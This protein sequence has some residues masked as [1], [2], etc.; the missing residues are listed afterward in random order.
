MD[1]RGFL[2]EVDEQG[3]VLLPSESQFSKG[4]DLVYR[5]WHTHAVTATV[6]G[7]V[8]CIIL[9]SSLMQGVKVLSPD[10]PNE[11][12]VL[13]SL[14]WVLGIG[15]GA[16]LAAL[17]SRTSPTAVG[18]ISAIPASLVWVAVIMQSDL[19]LPA[20]AFGW[21]PPAFVY[22]TAFLVLS[23]VAGIAGGASGDSMSFE[24][25]AEDTLT[26]V[27]GHIRPR[28]WWW[29][30]I[31]LSSWAYV[32]PTVAYLFWLALATGWHWAVHPSLWFNWRWFLFLSFGVVLTYLPYAVFVTGITGACAILA[33]GKNRRLRGFQVALRFIGWGYGCAVLGSGILS[34]MGFWVLG[35]LP[36][37]GAAS[38]PWWV[39]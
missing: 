13:N 39:F 37:A 17:L 14:A 27:V 1:P 23:L 19:Q 10:S 36:I 24:E 9:A 7:V 21:E 26:S 38:K 25:S 32:F 8:Y 11:H 31:P 33:Q 6:V 22:G 28:H 30:W 29:L 12:Y 16:R 35:K 15:I 20:V 34:F 18:A 5:L 4:D 2:T 3:G